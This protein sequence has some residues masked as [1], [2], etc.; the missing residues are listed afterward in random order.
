MFHYVFA[1]AVQDAVILFLC[2]LIPGEIFGI[3]LPY[4]EAIFL[5]HPDL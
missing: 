4:F 5:S 1:F 3:G 2:L